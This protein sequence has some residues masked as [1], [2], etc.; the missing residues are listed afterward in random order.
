VGEYQPSS[1]YDCG[2]AMSAMTNPESLK[3]AETFAQDFGIQYTNIRWS[4]KTSIVTYVFHDISPSEMTIYT[5]Q[6]PGFIV[7]KYVEELKP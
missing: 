6:I 2:G 5:T 3:M 7:R 1:S 4:D